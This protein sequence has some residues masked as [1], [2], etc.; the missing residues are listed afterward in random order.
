MQKDINTSGVKRHVDVARRKENLLGTNQ[1]PNFNEKA[2]DKIE[3][4]SGCACG[5]PPCWA[6]TLWLPSEKRPP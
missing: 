1:F 2:L 3:T 6:S 5:W 4:E